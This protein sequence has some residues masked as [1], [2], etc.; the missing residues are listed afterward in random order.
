MS[1]AVKYE[2]NIDFDL[3]DFNLSNHG[4]R[5]QDDITKDPRVSSEML[6]IFFKQ[7]VD[8]DRLRLKSQSELQNVKCCTVIQKYD[9]GRSRNSNC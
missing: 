6:A 5:S 8:E 9:A 7:M 2:L 3:T 1:N 4:E